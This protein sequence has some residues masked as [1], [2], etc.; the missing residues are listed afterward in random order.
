MPVA[1]AEDD[2][3]ASDDDADDAEYQGGP[4]IFDRRG[5]G[6]GRTLRGSNPAKHL[7]SLSTAETQQ[8]SA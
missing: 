4:T 3:D 5:S 2:A 7:P 6:P 8:G 1:Y